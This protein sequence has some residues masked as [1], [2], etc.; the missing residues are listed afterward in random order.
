MGRNSEDEFERNRAEI[1]RMT[2]NSNSEKK[3]EQQY[4]ENHKAVWEYEIMEHRKNKSKEGLMYF[5]SICGILSLLV[6]LFL[7]VNQF[8]NII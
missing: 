8:L 4:G 2:G 5:G 3:L 1:L 6:S 7:L